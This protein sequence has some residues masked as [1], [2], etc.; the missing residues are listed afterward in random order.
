[1]ATKKGQNA[2][3]GAGSIEN[4]SSYRN[5]DSKEDDSE[6]EKLGEL[7]RMALWDSLINLLVTKYAQDE[8]RSF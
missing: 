6:V 1:M 4:T 7:F 3:G 2:M 5:K 8:S